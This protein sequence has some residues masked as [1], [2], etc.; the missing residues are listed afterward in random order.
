MEQGPSWEVNSHSGSQQI[1]CLLLNPKVHY[2]VH[3]TPPL[4]PIHSQMNPVHTF[5]PYF[6]KIHS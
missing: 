5:S 4:V 2:R 6:L 3:N 1:T